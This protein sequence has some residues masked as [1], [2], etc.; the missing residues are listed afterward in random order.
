MT[1]EQWAEI[2]RAYADWVANRNNPPIQY[3]RSV[4]PQE[5]VNWTDINRI[6]RDY[7]FVKKWRVKPLPVRVRLRAEYTHVP[8]KSICVRTVR[9][10]PWDTCPE[11]LIDTPGVWLGSWQEIPETI[12]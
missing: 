3:L 8:P 6:S 11:F 5:W 7:S 12:D 1:D 10:D 2:L 9:W 4:D